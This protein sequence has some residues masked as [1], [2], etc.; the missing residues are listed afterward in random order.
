MRPG[1]R[2]R[3]PAPRDGVS[4]LQAGVAGTKHHARAQ[5]QAAAGTTCEPAAA[6]RPQEVFL[7]G[8]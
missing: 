3:C 2:A 8:T 1:G 4:A 5:L 7:E 6:R